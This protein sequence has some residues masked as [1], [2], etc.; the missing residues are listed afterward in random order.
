VE[1]L[2]IFRISSHLAEMQSAPQKRKAPFENFLATVLPKPRQK[3]QTIN[4][5][6]C[7]FDCFI[8]LCVETS[9]TEH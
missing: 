3:R 7:C 1:L 9:E 5:S 4:E 8:M 6:V 2:S